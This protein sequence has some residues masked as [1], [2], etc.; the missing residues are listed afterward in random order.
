[1]SFLLWWFPT[2]ADPPSLPSAL[3]R[4]KVSG[5]TVSASIAAKSLRKVV[6]TIRENGVG[7]CVALIQGKLG[8]GDVVEECGLIAEVKAPKVAA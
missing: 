6:A 1:M 4:I 2:R 5:R 8:P 7:Y 3:L